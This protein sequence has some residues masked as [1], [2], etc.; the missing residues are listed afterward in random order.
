LMNKTVW[1]PGIIALFLFAA[2]GCRD[3]RPVA[4]EY[5]KKG[6]ASWYSSRVTSSGERF[7]KN[8]LTCALRRNDFGGY[9]KV[10]NTEN[11]KCVTVRHNDFG[12][13]IGMYS[14]GRIIDLSR[15]AFSQIAELGD[16]LARVTVEALN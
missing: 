7:D 10:C 9:Y 5:P 16:G 14:R 13:S 3:D 12:P 2:C 11:N 4:G 1:V 15:Q 6:E 8:G